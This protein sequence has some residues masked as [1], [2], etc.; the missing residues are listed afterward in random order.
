[1]CIVYILH[2]YKYLL[3]LVFM[4]LAIAFLIKFSDPRDVYKVLLLVEFSKKSLNA[5]RALGQ[6]LQKEGEL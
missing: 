4:T 1:M 2:T 5:A 3:N 6:N